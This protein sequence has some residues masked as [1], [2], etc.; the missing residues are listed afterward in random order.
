MEINAHVL[1]KSMPPEKQME[2]IRNMFDDLKSNGRQNMIKSLETL[3]RTFDS[4]RIDKETLGVMLDTIRG[5]VRMAIDPVSSSGSGSMA[6]A[7][8]N[9]HS[10][11]SGHNHDESEIHYTGIGMDETPDTYPASSAEKPLPVVADTAK[12]RSKKKV[13]PEK[14]GGGVDEMFTN[15]SR[16]SASAM[17][18]AL[19]DGTIHHTNNHNHPATASNVK[20]LIKIFE[21]KSSSAAIG[22]GSAKYNNSI[23]HL[24]SGDGRPSAKSGGSFVAHSDMTAD[25]G[26]DVGT[27]RY[28]AGDGPPAKFRTVN[29]NDDVFDG[30]ATSLVSLPTSVTTVVDKLSVSNLLN[31]K[32]NT[33][34]VE[35][36]SMELLVEA[37]GVFNRVIEHI[38]NGMQELQK[39]FE[40]NPEMS[41]SDTQFYGYGDERLDY[42]TDSR[43]NALLNADGKGVH[44]AKNYQFLKSVGISEGA[45]Q[46]NPTL[47]SIAKEREAQEL[48]V[49]IG[50]V[51]KTAYSMA[52]EE[53][54]YGQNPSVKREKA[55]NLFNKSVEKMLNSVSHCGIGASELIVMASKVSE[56]AANQAIRDSSSG[57]RVPKGSGIGG[58]SVRDVSE[59]GYTIGR[60]D[61][62]SAYSDKI[63]YARAKGYKPEYS[64]L[65]IQNTDT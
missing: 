64:R 20:E 23:S 19:K 41:L 65:K 54:P 12:G 10:T 26:S 34:K 52:S 17:Y 49:L 8:S 5:T 55:E 59:A 35:M 60:K 13:S 39:E 36:M 62:G 31:E 15:P 9:S 45:F 25:F 18:P 2:F 11:P 42:K 43:I 4:D 58:I 44:F 24:S 47:V 1:E 33:S 6:V 32:D 30:G 3:V 57:G 48:L 46:A 27:K 38:R 22:G 29:Y 63:R 16:S 40:D 37:E 53:I 28:S 56:Y 50:E 51:Y 14:T 7:S 21:D 61:R